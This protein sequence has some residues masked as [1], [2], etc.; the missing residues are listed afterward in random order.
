MGLRISELA[1][2]VGVASSTVRYYERIGLVPAPARTASGYRL[3][4]REA[5]ARLLF[6]IRG[7]RLG[8][9]LEEIADLLAVW[10]GTNCGATQERLCALLGAKRAEIG[11]QIRELERFADQLADVEARLAAAPV[12][13]GCA[14]DLVCCAP[15][16]T[17]APVAVSLSERRPFGSG[18]APEEAPAIA[19]TLTLAEW[20]ARL[21]MFEE[22]SV[23]VRCWTRADTSLRL[24]FPAQPDVEDL[25]RVVMAREQVCC[26]FLTFAL[27]RVEDEWWW[28]IDAPDVGAAPALDE[29][30]PLLPPARESRLR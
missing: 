29:F 9:S 8:L 2:R 15:E 1:E 17:A 6:I 18:P 10:D 5:E 16:L 14:P 13:E 24:R 27:R 3:Y 11:E 21:R 12:V 20:P 22:L 28:D 25:L 19:C 4:G 26:A 30:L 23:H 7:K